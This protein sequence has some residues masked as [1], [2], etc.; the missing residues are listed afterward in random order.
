MLVGMTTVSARRGPHSGARRLA[1]LMI[2]LTLTAVACGSDD[3][4]GAD[5]GADSDDT[6]AETAAPAETEETAEPADTTAATEAE[7]SGEG[8]GGGEAAA[9]SGDPIKVMTIAPVNSQLPPYPNIQ[10]AAEVYEQYINDRGGVAG[11]PLEMIFCDDQGDP[12]VAADCARQGVEEGVVAV[13]GSFVFDASGIISVLE[14]ANTAW[15]GACCPLV[16]QEFQSPISF[17]L[18]SLF[19]AQ[20]A[21][22]GWK[23]AQDGCESVVV[24]YVDIPAGDAAHPAFLAAYE[25]GG[26]DPANVRVVKIPL[27]AQDY[28]AQVAEA[29]EGGTDCI[30]G[31]ISDSN[32]ATWLPGMM[33][34]GAE[35]VT[36]YGL[37]GNLNGPIAEQFP[38]ITEGA[39]V[40]NSYPNISGAMWDDYNAALEEYEADPELDYNS[41][42]GLGTW[43]AF[44]AFKQV[45]DGMEG[46]IDNATFID[47]A[48][49]TTSLDTGGMIPVLDLTTPWDG[50]G[51]AF[52]RIFNR[53]VFFDVISG[54]ALTPLDDQSYDMTGPIDGQPMG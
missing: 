3:S 19:P 30:A 10:A 54:G 14:E 23:M 7:G 29:L 18:G 1:G 13:V 17:P 2:A 37:Q 12:N 50:Y 6:S 9:P 25:V 53:V 5:D 21:G 51:G 52:P 33:A 44:T 27:T 35:G 49:A 20:G 36:L 48:N 15:F 24:V 26:G 34:A 41:L 38:E 46:E 47:A 39:I 45:V 11:R 32:W 42:A 31:G 22:N 16:T 43:T 28:S 8:D 40:S 4:G